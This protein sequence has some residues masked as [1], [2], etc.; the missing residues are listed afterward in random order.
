MNQHQIKIMNY[1][2]PP[3]EELLVKKA[4]QAYALARRW[5][6]AAISSG[7]E[8]LLIRSDRPALEELIGNA[9]TRQLLS[10]EVRE[11]IEYLAG[12]CARRIAEL[13]DPDAPATRS[14]ALVLHDSSER[15]YWLMGV[16][17][18]VLDLEQALRTRHQIVART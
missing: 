18:E 12:T 11:E 10:P 1:P 17:D 3:A 9:R 13:T 14:K 4:T 5:S 8:G 6:E 15:L 2:E 16:V 7:L